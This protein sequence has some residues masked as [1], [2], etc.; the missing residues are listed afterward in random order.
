VKLEASTTLVSVSTSSLVFSMSMI[1]AA[2]TPFDDCEVAATQSVK[3]TF[4]KSVKA[5]K[6]SPSSK[7]S[8]IHSA[9]SPPRVEVDVSDFVTVFPIVR[10][11]MVAEP[12]VVVVALTYMEMTCSEVSLVI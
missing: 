6:L 4:P 8:T 11:S 3:V 10:F 2:L 5:I 1:V 7:S 12:E 9:F